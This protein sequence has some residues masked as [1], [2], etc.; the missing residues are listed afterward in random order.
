MDDNELKQVILTRFRECRTIASEFYG[1][2]FSTIKVNIHWDLTGQVAGQFCAR[3]NEDEKYYFRV[4]LAF[5]RANLDDYLSDT[6]PHEYAHFIVWAYFKDYKCN[7]GSNWQGVMWRCFNTEPKRCHNYDLSTVID[8]YKWKCPVCGKEYQLTL[9][10]HNDLILNRK[11]WSCNNDGKHPF[12]R[13]V[14]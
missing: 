5:A 14:Q 12:A 9:K 2:D 13:L 11:N 1:F 10:R 8:T 3:E 7:H 4:N 6:I